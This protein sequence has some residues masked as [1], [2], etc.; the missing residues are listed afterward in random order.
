MHEEYKT[1]MKSNI[2]SI[3]QTGKC[4]ICSEFFVETVLTHNKI[5]PV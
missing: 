5:V 2:T 1:K 4:I 3:I